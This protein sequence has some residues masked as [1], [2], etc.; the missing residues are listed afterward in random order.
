MPVFGTDAYLGI[1]KC[2]Q[3]SKAG[4]DEALS[5]PAFFPSRSFIFD[6]SNPSPEPSVLAMAATLSCPN[7]HIFLK[8]C[9]MVYS[10]PYAAQPD[11]G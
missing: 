1:Y 9:C 2:K 7:K 4:K 10:S 3:L 5:R 11:A 6:P 8:V